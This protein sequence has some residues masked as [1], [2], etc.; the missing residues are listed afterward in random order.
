VGPRE[1]DLVSDMW[2]AVGVAVQIQALDPDTLTSVCCPT[3][4]YDVI[5]WGWG[6]DPDPA[7]LLGV[8]LCTEVESGFNETG[9]CNPTYDELYDQ[10][11]IQTDVTER[12]E[13]I[14]EMQRILMEDM[15]YI[16]P[17]YDQV[18]QAFRTDTFTGWPIGNPT[19]GLESPESLTTIRPVQ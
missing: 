1:A 17:Y 11:N 6:V 18:I 2:R 9:Y 19:L 16:V 3:F 13:T 15:P 4:D 14:R 12:G 7:F 8:A 5:R 10:Q